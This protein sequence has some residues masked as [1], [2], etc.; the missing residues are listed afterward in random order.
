VRNTFLAAAIVGVLAAGA[1]GEAPPAT[2]GGAEPVKVGDVVFTADFDGPAPLEGWS[3]GAGKLAADAGQGGGRALLIERPAG[4]PPASAFVEAPLPVEKVRGCTL[5]LSASVKAEAVSPKPQPWNGIKFMAPTV[6]GEHRAWA[7]AELG[8]GTFDWQ[9]VSWQTHV[10]RDASRMRLVLGL[11]NV[12]GKAWFDNV[13]VTVRRP[14]AA[15]AAAP[16]GPAYTGHALPRLRGAMVSPDAKEEDLRVLGREWNANLVRWQLCGFKPRID[17]GDLAAYDAFLESHLKR[18]D[19]A[20]PLCEKHGLLAVVDLHTGPGHWAPPGRSLFTS[21]AC[22]K[23][24]VEIWRQIAR[25]YKDSRAV[26]GYDL[27]NEPLEGAVAEDVDDWQGLAER[28]ARAVR[29]IDPR[30][31]IIVEPAPGGSPAA[32]ANLRPLPV[33]HIVYSIHMYS[34][35]IFTHQGVHDD[36]KRTYVYPGAAEGRQWDKAAL[37]AALRPVAEFQKTYGVHIYI[38]EFGAVRWAPDSSAGRYLGD[39]VAIFEARGWDWTYHAFREWHGWSAEHGP[40]RAD[41]RPAAQPTDRQRL[42]C[43]WFAGN[44][45]PRW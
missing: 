3:A 2:A 21:A 38:G 22:Q 45:K 41:T 11:E 1:S 7:Q 14:P 33:P 31:A 40:D 29:E 36:G 18:L 35:G 32:L 30:R 16:A 6:A 43:E 17:T 28:A 34:P 26:W 19:A 27:L 42:L 8:T 5:I 23:R 24:F 44:Q 39:L 20:L 4:A 37:E 13:K 10:P 12:T 9:R 25:R 15:P